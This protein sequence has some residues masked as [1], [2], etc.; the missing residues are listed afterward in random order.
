V[1]QVI[2]RLTSSGVAVLDSRNSITKPR[3]DLYGLVSITNPIIGFAPSSLGFI[4]AEGGVFPAGKTLSI[5]N[6]GAGTLNW[7]VS[8]SA[9]WLTPAPGSGTAPG[10]V[11][12]S[13]NTTGLSTG[14]YNANL[15]ITAAGALNT[16]MT[17]PVTLEINNAAY[18]EDFETGDLTKFPWVTGGNGPWTITDSTLGGIV[19]TGRYAVRSAAITDSQSSYLQ[20]TLDITSPGYV[21]F[22][23]RTSTQPTWDKIKFDVDGVN[24]GPF[25]GWSGNTDWT[26]VSSEHEV[27]A[28]IHTFKWIYSKDGSVS[29]GSDA[30]WLDDIFFPPSIPVAASSTVRLSGPPHSYYSSLAAAYAAAPGGDTIQSQASVF[31][32]NLSCSRNISVTLKGGYDSLF[33]T[34]AAFTTINGSLTITDGTVTVENIV[35]Q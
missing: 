35:I 15:T 20:V 7:V 19:H 18:S 21:Y 1:D 34:N 12:L 31:A 22:W 32:E 8:S 17:V 9:G 23:V 27:S 25:Y 6:D 14:I 29:A 30:V 33:T 26:F 13:L 5:T 10:N 2:S 11:T 24:E 16:P 3:V 28:G 4:G